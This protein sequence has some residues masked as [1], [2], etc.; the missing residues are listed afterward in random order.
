MI[1]AGTRV[2]VAR[3]LVG[4]QDEW[5]VDEGPSHGYPL[6]L[7]TRELVGAPVHLLAQPDQLED[8][9]HLR[10]DEVPRPTY[11]LQGE[12]DVLVHGPLGQQTVI[13]EN[14]AD[15]PPQVGDLPRGKRA[16][17]FAGHPDLTFVGP[18]L[19]RDKAQERR[20]ARA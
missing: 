13:L 11:D 20:L 18:F 8:L 15:V 16:Y 2:E 1:P 3:G 5:P 12:G 4:Q 19:F 9:G 14:A 7:A 6:L 17:L 10:A